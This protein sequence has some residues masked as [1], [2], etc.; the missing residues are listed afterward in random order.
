M[1]SAAALALR[2]LD[3]RDPAVGRSHV[4]RVACVARP[5]PAVG[6]G[7][8]GPDRPPHPEPAGR[9]GEPGPG[10]EGLP[11]R[12]AGA[13]PTPPTSAFRCIPLSELHGTPALHA[14]A[15]GRR[16]RAPGNEG[17]RDP[18]GLP[19]ACSGVALGDGTVDAD[20]VVVA[21][22]NDRVGRAASAG[23]DA[24]PGAFARLGSSPIVNLHVVYETARHA[25]SVRG[26]GRLAR[27]VDLRPDRTVRAGPGAVHRR[28]AV[29]RRRVRR[30]D[31][32]GSPRRIPARTE[33][34]CSRTLGPF[35]SNGFS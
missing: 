31:G 29:G 27:P 32:G 4:R 25:P 24:R 18:G 7:A 20:A 3:P 6:P 19:T 11:D 34:G 26:G 21:V 17:P 2:R 28:L 12:A 35:P 14:L 8:V 30:S 1:P 33:R 23:R 22:P 10:R 13:R 9:R 16:G 15:G 5:V